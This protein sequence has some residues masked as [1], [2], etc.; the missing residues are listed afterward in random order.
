MGLGRTVALIGASFVGVIGGHMIIRS[1]FSG[2]KNSNHNG[3][4]RR[5]QR[6]PL[7][8]LKYYDLGAPNHG[9]ANQGVYASSP[10]VNSQ[11]SGGFTS[12]VSFGSGNDGNTSN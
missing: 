8:S 12:T 3:Q 5:E 4:G 10:Q 7:D 1:I 6:D 9:R 2:G 11:P